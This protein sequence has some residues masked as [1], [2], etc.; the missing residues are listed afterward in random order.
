MKKKFLA[1]LGALCIITLVGCGADNTVSSN[2]EKDVEESTPS[3]NEVSDDESLLSADE[4]TNTEEGENTED[5]TDTEETNSEEDEQN[6]LSGNEKVDS[7]IEELITLSDNE[8][9][10]DAYWVEEGLL[11][12][13]QVN[14]IDTPDNQYDREMDWFFYVFDE[15]NISAFP[16]C[17]STGDSKEGEHEVY[18]ACDFE[19]RLEDVTFDG[20]EDI[21]VFVG[22]EGA[23]GALVYCAYV[24]T[25]TDFVNVSSFEDI[26]NYEVDMDNGVINGSY[27]SQGNTVNQV[28]TYDS[29]NME[30]NLTSE[31]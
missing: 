26:P 16:V 4:T 9:I 22:Y 19:V 6:T 5:I 23:Q 31:D 18:A 7:M 27:V 13:V 24:N 28:Y 17:Y 10:S 15:E 30:F 8:Q 21:L 12:R 25:G 14:Y 3:A 1:M 29:D 2:D 11:Y 20:L